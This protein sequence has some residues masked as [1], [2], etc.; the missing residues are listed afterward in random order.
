MSA[1]C[2]FDP[3][4]FCTPS[5]D[6]TFEVPA[7]DGGLDRRFIVAATLAKVVAQVLAA[8]DA[9]APSKTLVDIGDPS[10]PPDFGDTI[11][12]GILAPAVI[13]A[14][15]Q[16]CDA[17]LIDRYV[18]KVARCRAKRDAN[19]T[20]PVGLLDATDPVTVSGSAR[21]LA[22][23]DEALRLGL[24]R[25]W[26]ETWAACDWSTPG[27]GG[28]TITESRLEANGTHNELRRFVQV[29]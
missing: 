18:L 16:R 14:D 13:P 5:P 29:A 12:V 28:L 20:W 11:A 7:F 8:V 2:C 6:A 25:I 10:I 22:R 19:G 3:A 27:C 21:L 24:D 26:C 4:E 9:P 17:K 15:G 23:D 1:D